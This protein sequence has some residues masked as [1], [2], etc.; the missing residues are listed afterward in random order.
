MS[1]EIKLDY[2]E[3]KSALSELKSVAAQFES[4]LASMKDGENKLDMV[5]E[6]NEVKQYFDE[7]VSSYQQLLLK[8][9][10][11]TLQTIETMKETDKAIAS[12]MK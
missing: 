9:T 4:S 2:A 10:E 5:N 1:T 6:L 8:S 7:L 3:V 12:S 11:V